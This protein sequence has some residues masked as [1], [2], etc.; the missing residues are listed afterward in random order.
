MRPTTTPISSPVAMQT[1]SRPTTT[2]ISSSI[3]VETASAGGGDAEPL[4]F[5]GYQKVEN[6]PN[7]ILMPAIQPEPASVIQTVIMNPGGGGFPPFCLF[8][9]NLAI[10]N[11]SAKSEIDPEGIAICGFQFADE[12]TIILTK[13]DGSQM[14]ASGLAR[15]LFQQDVLSSS[16]EYIESAYCIDA[17]Q[18]LLPGQYQLTIKSAEENLTGKFQIQSP[19][20]P[21]IFLG[22]SCRFFSLY[23]IPRVPS[24]IPGASQYIVEGKPTHIFYNGFQPNESVRIAVYRFD[25]RMLGEH[26]DPSTHQTTGTFESI[27]EKVNSW[28]AQ[29]DGNGRLVEYIEEP[30]LLSD[31]T[32]LIVA[33][34]NQFET[35]DISGITVEAS[36]TFLWKGV[37]SKQNPQST[38][39]QSPSSAPQAYAFSACAQPCN[40]ANATSVF[41]EGTTRVY[42]QWN[43]E[44]IPAGAEYTRVWTMNEQEWV[45]YSCIW[46]GPQTGMDAVTLTEP[47]GLHSGTWEMTI[48][49]NGQVLLKE[50]VQ[51]DGNWT[52]WDPAGSLD[53]CYGKR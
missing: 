26:T 10:A 42:A 3:P 28:A 14:T 53:T 15:D 50:Q 9:E 36:A 29:M 22:E 37:T 44:S 17:Q 4:P 39:T 1:T 38:A 48:T 7:N 32:Y 30:K 11:L 21:E 25:E 27:L 16:G 35:R 45:R 47:Q 52:Y 5:P 19:S 41:A 49:V 6:L 46:P 31:G 40:G 2:P 43:Y 51:V 24:T 18:R 23:P 13:P 20:K 34:G 8:A 33:T 12:V